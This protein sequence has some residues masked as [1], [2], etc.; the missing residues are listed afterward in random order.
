MGGSVSALITRPHLFNFTHQCGLGAT[1]GQWLLGTQSYTMAISGN[2]ELSGNLTEIQCNQSK[3][4]KTNLLHFCE[5]TLLKT[6]PD[7]LSI[8][9]K[10][11]APL[12]GMRDSRKNNT[13]LK[14]T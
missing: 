12:L 5:N 10:K 1:G 11:W 7:L 13:Q 14:R 2:Q 6:C 8:S 3:W 9:S 4:F